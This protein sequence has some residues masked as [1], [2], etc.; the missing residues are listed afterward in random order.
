MK[1]GR[2]KFH[3]GASTGPRTASGLLASQNARRI[4]GRSSRRARL[5]GPILKELNV[6]AATLTTGDLDARCES[7]TRYQALEARAA[8][9]SL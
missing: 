6:L 3:G 5:V 8:Y 9:K 1:N 2:C 4:H 7:W